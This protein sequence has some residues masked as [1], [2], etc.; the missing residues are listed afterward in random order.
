MGGGS[1]ICAERV[2][3]MVSTPKLQAMI[4]KLGS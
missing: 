1:A 3:A 2:E 4:K